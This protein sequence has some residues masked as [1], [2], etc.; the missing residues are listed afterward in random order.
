MSIKELSPLKKIIGIIV[1]VVLVV[2]LIGAISNEKNKI[3]H[4]VVIDRSY[5]APFTSYTYSGDVKV[6][7]YHA[8]RFTLTIRGEKNGKTVEYSFSVPESEYVQYQI[9]DNYPKE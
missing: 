1:V 8:A 2:T 4:G 5:T 3:S 9:G 6:P 7:E